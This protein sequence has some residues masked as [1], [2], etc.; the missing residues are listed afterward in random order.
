MNMKLKLEFGQRLI[1]SRYLY[2]DEADDPTGEIG[3][4]SDDC[5]DQVKRS[6]MKVIIML[7]T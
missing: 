2:V 7:L 3:E 1:F 5:A 4:L 6:I